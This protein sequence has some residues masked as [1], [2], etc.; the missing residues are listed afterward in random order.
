MKISLIADK[1]GVCTSILCM[2]HCLAI[3]ILLIMGID[4]ILLLI[5]QEWIELTIIGISFVIGLIA[6]IGGYLQHKQHFVP[7]LFIA[8]FLLLINGESVVHTGVSITL[9]VTGALVILYAHVQ[10]LKW[11]RYAFV[12]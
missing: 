11:K 12:N 3:P 6:F 7:V 9:S 8:G 5:D 4:S 2:I 10:N 1:V